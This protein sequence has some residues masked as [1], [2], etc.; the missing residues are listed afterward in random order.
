MRIA[1]G[2]LVV[3]RQGVDLQIETRQ[4]AP[5]DSRIELISATEAD[6][7]M[8]QHE[9]LNIRLHKGL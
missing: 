7:N 5:L 9:L 8:L 3:N 6:W 2:T 4:I 1:E